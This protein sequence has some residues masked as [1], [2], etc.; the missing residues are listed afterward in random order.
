MVSTDIP[1]VREALQP[2]YELALGKSEVS[3][4]LP[5]DLLVSEIFRYTRQRPEGDDLR[6]H[7]YW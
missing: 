3:G 4:D 7:P 5:L 6:Q 2:A 1:D